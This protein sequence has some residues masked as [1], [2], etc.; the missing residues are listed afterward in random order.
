MA[1]ST[2]TVLCQQL[3]WNSLLLLHGKAAWNCALLFLATVSF[4]CAVLTQG[5]EVGVWCFSRLQLSTGRG[6]FFPEPVDAGFCLFF[7]CFL[8]AAGRLVYSWTFWMSFLELGSQARLRHVHC[9][10]FV[11]RRHVCC[12]IFSVLVSSKVCRASSVSEAFRCWV[13]GVDA[14]SR[15][16]ACS[17]L[18]LGCK[19]VQVE[20]VPYTFLSATYFLVCET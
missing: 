6:L 5:L 17:P 11:G 8:A 18:R 3:P 16:L 20:T 14:T 9:C 1:G 19:S 15:F 12:R 13:R 10:R 4:S 7:C 2:S